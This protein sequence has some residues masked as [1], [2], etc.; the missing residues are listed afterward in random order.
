MA[1]RVVLSG[2]MEASEGSVAVIYSVARVASVEHMLSEHVGVRKM[3]STVLDCFTALADNNEELRIEAGVKLLEHVY[4]KQVKFQVR[5]RNLN[6][7][8]MIVCFSL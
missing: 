4:G 6:G 3:D 2:K 1:N 7:M 8:H 5:D